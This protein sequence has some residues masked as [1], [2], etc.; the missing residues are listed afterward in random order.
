MSNGLLALVGA[1]QSTDATRNRFVLASLNIGA[2]G[3]AF[4]RQRNSAR[5][6]RPTVRDDG[7]DLRNHVAGAAHDHGVA[8][9][10]VLALDLVHV[11][12]R[13]VADGDATDEDGLQASDGRKRASPP[14]LPPSTGRIS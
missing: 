10:H 12:Q 13:C 9:T 2:T 11:V 3:R 4:G 1:K 5:V 8:D 7:N 6:R 14:D